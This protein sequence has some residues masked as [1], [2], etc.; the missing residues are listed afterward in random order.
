MARMTRSRRVSSCSVAV[1]R[2]V[3][4]FQLV[5]KG[6]ELPFLILGERRRNRFQGPEI[7]VMI[8]REIDGGFDPAPA[9]GLEGLGFGGKLFA[10]QPFEQG[11]VLQ[12][13]AVIIV[14]QIADD[15]AARG[16]VRVGAD[17]DRA[18]VAGMHRFLGEHAADGVGSLVP[19]L[20]DGVED[21][22]LPLVIVGEAK[23]HELI[24]GDF[25]I[26]VGLKENRARLGET[27]ALFHHM[28]R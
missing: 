4:R 24:E 8:P 9:F 28:R 6:L 1:A 2:F 25:V 15:D 3:K 21:L 12:I 19:L 18:A 11:H 13:A 22:L 17:E 5:E 16:L 14:E 7:A 27:Q 10:D 26:L 23:R 20:L